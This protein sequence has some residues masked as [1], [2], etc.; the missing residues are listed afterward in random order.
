MTGARGEDGRSDGGGGG[1]AS[2]LF[3]FLLLSTM[4]TVPLLPTATSTLPPP[5]FYLHTPLPFFCRE[6]LV[7]GDRVA[8]GVWGLQ[9][10]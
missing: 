3:L 5:R 7:V 9:L 4:S 1:G 8:A 10:F 6:E 2:L